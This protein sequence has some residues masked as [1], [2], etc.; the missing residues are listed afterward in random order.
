MLRLAKSMTPD[1]YPNAILVRETVDTGPYSPVRGVQATLYPLLQR[2]A[3]NRLADVHPSGSFMKGTANLSGTDIDLFV[4]LSDQTTETLKQIYDKLFNFMEENGYSPSRQNVS[5]NLRVNGYSVDLVPAKRQNSYSDDHSLYRRRAD[6]WTKT[7]VVSHINHVIASSRQR[8][9][10]ILKLWRDQKHLDFP[11]FFL[12]LLVI[13]AL[14][15][16]LSETL[17]GNVWRAL[18]YIKANIASARIVDP[19]NTNN[20]VSAELSAA[21]K[22]KLSTAAATALRASTWGDIVL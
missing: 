17:S 1:E 5:I 2:W 9:I 6:T 10:R 22:Q 16:H 20:I 11:S 21:D 3:G 13:E 14:P 4:S 18:E 12:E 7:N 15:W 8:E 19:A